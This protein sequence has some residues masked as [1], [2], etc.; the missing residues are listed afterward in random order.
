[1]QCHTKAQILN[2]SI[3]NNQ[4]VTCNGM[5]DGSVTA[6]ATG[7][8]GNYSFSWSNGSTN[9]NISNLCAGSYSVVVNDGATQDTAYATVIQPSQLTINL[10]SPTPICPGGTVSICSNMSGGTPPYTYSWAPM[11]GINISTGSCPVFSG[12]VTTSYTLTVVD[13]NGCV[14]TGN[15]SA[16]VNNVNAVATNTGPYCSGANIQLFATGGGSYI[17]SGP[18]GF[19]SNLSN[20]AALNS[21]T[22]MSGIYT[23]TVTSVNGC[24]STATTSVIVNSLP[25]ALPFVNNSNCSGTNL[26]LYANA[27]GAVAYNWI[28][29]NNFNST[30]QNP[31]IYNAQL[32]NSGTY[33]LNITSNFA[34]TSTSTLSV[35]VSPSPTLTINSLTEPSCNSSNGSLIINA[36]GGTIPFFYS[37][38][39][40]GVGNFG[41]TVNPSFSNICSG[42]ANLVVT[43][44]NG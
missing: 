3:T 11:T 37:G 8:T 26:I 12:T 14:A 30:S 22:A 5:C 23:V 41:P 2:V 36:S 4:S 13:A 16:I 44:A 38:N 15:V 20:P 24:T 42:Q 35:M 21:T 10:N 29:P 6:T 40:C 32:F 17:W 27:Q 33:T 39:L 1:M 7:G 34:C 19:T 18:N 25:T 43:D 28:G 31:I 9:N